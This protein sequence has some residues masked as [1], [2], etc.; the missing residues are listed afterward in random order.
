MWKVKI[1][2]VT[3]LVVLSA[4]C[5]GQ[6]STLGTEAYDDDP[7]LLEFEEIVPGVH[8]ATR[9][10]P[11]RYI[12]EGN[13]TIIVNDEDVVVVDGSGSPIAARRV[14][15]HIRSLTEKPVSVLVNTHGHG[16]HTL[17]N[18]EYVKAYPGV[19]IV[20]HSETYKYL[21]GRGI[22]Y[23]ADIATSTQ[24]RKEAGF[25]E[26][27]RLRTEAAPGYEAVIANLERYYGHVIDVRQVEYRKTT[28][29][30]PTLTVDDELVL[31]RK[32][33]TIRVMHL[34][35]GD[36]AGDLIV[37]LPGDGVVATG[38]MVV[39]PFPY[40]FSR[41][42]LE[43]RRTLERVDSLSFEILVPG[44]GAV[45]R[46]HGYLREVHALLTS[47]QDQLGASRAAGLDR[48]AAVA[49]VDV[50]AFEDRMATDDPV[51]RYFFE[52]YFVKPNL[53]RT[54]EAMER[55]EA[56]CASRKVDPRPKLNLTAASSFAQRS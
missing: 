2:A 15:R 56:S 38:D 32:N 39:A 27:E 45:Q 21:T 33:R 26:I 53:T 28:V 8:V 29:T 43:W 5:S 35:A 42:P 30:P 7:W 18:E 49:S 20:A 34:G 19:E 23:V 14:I 37:Y 52:E 9:P 1:S 12:V 47:V 6:G 55:Q 22:G 46:G 3:F 54:F 48:E 16:D 25:A 31:H 44:H 24:S 41:H 11:L 50:S 10:E 51:V 4:A 17:G 40:G 13:V 36:T